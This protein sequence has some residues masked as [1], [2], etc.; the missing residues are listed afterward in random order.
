MKLIY[1]AL[2]RPNLVILACLAYKEHFKSHQSYLCV[3]CSQKS[4]LL[5][6]VYRHF[7][8][9]E[10]SVVSEEHL[11][12]FHY[13]ILYISWAFLIT[14]SIPVFVK[15]ISGSLI[16]LNFPKLAFGSANMTLVPSLSSVH[17]SSLLSR[18]IS[19]RI[20]CNHMT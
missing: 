3:Q 16:K 19:F 9:C 15:S 7:S 12:V 4:F 8:K 1:E 18:K 20:Y 14:E 6:F 11:F 5:Q 17:V 10:C 2:I 13:S